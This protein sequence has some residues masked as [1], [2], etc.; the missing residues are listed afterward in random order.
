MVINAIAKKCQPVVLVQALML[1]FEDDAST[2]RR[3][4]S[5]EAVA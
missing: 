2:E 1:N 4:Q 3:K 5:Q